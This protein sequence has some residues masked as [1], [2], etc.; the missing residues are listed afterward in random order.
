[1]AYK[2]HKIL[3]FVVLIIGGLILSGCNKDQ[4]T[5][6]TNPPITILPPSPSPTPLQTEEPDITISPFPTISQKDSSSNDSSTTE[7]TSEGAKALILERLDI[8]KYSV[9][10]IDS[11]LSL[12]GNIYYSFLVREGNRI[13]EPALIVDKA[14]GEI[15]CY[16]SSGT[17]SD[18]SNFPLYNETL[19]TVCDWNGTFYLYDSIGSVMAELRL[20]QGDP[21]SF[22]F[23]IS[24][25][26]SE[27]KTVTAVASI[28]SNTASYIS[29]E[30]DSLHFVMSDLAVA[31]TE[32]YPNSTIPV[33]AGV[34]FPSEQEANL[35]T[36][37][38]KT[39]A[40]ALLSTLT[41]KDTKLSQE[42]TEYRLSA[43]D[44]TIKIKNTLC[45]SIG[46]YPKSEQTSS[47]LTTFYVALDGSRIYQFNAQAKDDIEIWTAK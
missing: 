10:L 47:L 16:D 42:L 13:F 11:S 35:P 19:D 22:E 46:V 28:Q 15:F 5:D 29:P 7:L 4:K 6:M 8:T 1:M 9:D 2:I 41:K 18:Y 37:L 21:H 3:L 17:I 25:K 43:D 31:V 44:L 26:G 38:T 27:T 32:E 20:G 12:K 30:G 33:F 24:T 39:Q 34:Y 45:Y 40:V 14:S 36:P 23:T